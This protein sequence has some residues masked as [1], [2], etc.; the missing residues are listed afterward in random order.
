VSLTGAQNGKDIVMTRKNRTISIIVGAL[1]LVSAPALAQDA[2]QAE[3]RHGTR[4]GAVSVAPEGLGL[5]LG[6]GVTGFSRQATRD[7]LGT[8]GYWD[9]RVVYG[10]RSYLGAELGYVGSARYSRSS[11]GPQLLGNGAEAALRANLPIQAGSVRLTPFLF[12]GVGWTYYSSINDDINWGNRDGHALAI[13]FGAG[14]GAAF[15]GFTIDARFTYRSV[16]DDD[17]V[18]NQQGASHFA[19]LQNWSAGL[20]LGYEI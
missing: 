20:T 9:A 10:T 2:S 13:P 17:L 12:G 7:E 19:D 5:Q 1:A 18:R 14:L 3:I 6:G 15:N 8:G 16:F 4:A 11:G